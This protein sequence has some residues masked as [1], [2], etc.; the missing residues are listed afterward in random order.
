MTGRAAAI[1][2]NLALLTLGA[3]I[4]SFGVKGIVV[5]KG[6]MSGGLSGVALLLHYL[7]GLLGPGI[8]YFLLNLPLMVLGWVSLSRRFILY[9]LYGMGA[10][11]VFLDIL[12]ALAL[13]PD[14]LLAA[15]FGGS[16]MGAGTGIMLRT[17][18]SSGG[19]DILAIW[20]NQKYD[21]R[22]GQLNFGFNLALFS[23][24]L[25]F[26]DVTLVLYSVILSYAYSRVMDYFL[27][28][29]NQ[30]KMVLI[31]SDEAQ[32]I[33]RDIIGVLRR[34]ATILHGEGAY[35]GNPKRV[36]LTVANTIQIKRLE[37]LVFAHDPDAFVVVESTF[38]V[39]GKGFSHRKTY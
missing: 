24:G 27:A 5:S 38:N 18:G 4:F 7:T 14:T 29:F 1:A 34:G 11:S 15:V 32:A 33:A 35:T 13:I 16:V 9:T 19:T 31:I 2:W 20:L 3:A 10:M 6:L 26:Y 21:L 25:A 12:P 23:A 36:I 37:E 30:R 8:L 39:L 17:L 22:I 28:L